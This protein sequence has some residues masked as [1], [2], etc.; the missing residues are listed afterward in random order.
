MQGTGYEYFESARKLA[1]K[2]YNKSVSNGQIGYLPSLEGI[3]KDTEIVSQV[4]LGLIEIPLNKII[5]TYTHLRSLSFANNFMPLLE[6]EFKDKWASL[7]IAHINE[8]IR[9]PIKVYEYLNWFYVMEGNKR[10]SVLKF[11]DAYSLSAKVTRLIPKFDENDKN[12][13]LYYEFLKFNNKTGIYTIWL[14][15]KA[16]LTSYFH[17]WMV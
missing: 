15:K 3:L 2:E 7:C 10:V 8:G 5:G 11:F 1:V 9:D 17:Y 6:T 4:D 14:Q 16:A 13:R 12:I